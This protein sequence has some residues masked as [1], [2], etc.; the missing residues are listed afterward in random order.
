MCSGEN[1][2]KTQRAGR[3]SERLLQGVEDRRS[4]AGS[5][6]TSSWKLLW[7]LTW[8]LFLK[9]QILEEVDQKCTTI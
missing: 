1:E 4:H 5:V 2:A 3:G 7:V 8:S 6:G 9:R